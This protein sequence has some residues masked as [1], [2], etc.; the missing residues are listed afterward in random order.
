MS[1]TKLYT[2]I[3]FIALALLSLIAFQ[4]YWVKNTYQIKQEQFDKDAKRALLNT[5]E[6]S[7]KR[8]L[9]TADEFLFGSSSGSMPPKIEVKHLQ[10]SLMNSIH[11]Q[12]DGEDAIEKTTIDSFKITNIDVNNSWTTGSVF[13][14]KAI[15]LNTDTQIDSLYVE[16]I[17]TT[18]K[19]LFN[20]KP[21][22]PNYAFLD[23]VLATEFRLLGLGGTYQFGVLNSRKDSMLYASSYDI[24]IEF[25]K[26]NE[27]Y[28][29][30]LFSNQDSPYVLSVFFPNREQLILRRMLIVF[31][32]SIL[33]VLMIGGGFAYVLRVVMMQ[34]KLSEM[35]NDFINNMTH[36]LKTPIANIGLSLEALL[37][38]GFI[39]NKEKRS[40]Y[41]QIA[42]K[43]NKRLSGLVEQVLKAAAFEKGVADFKMEEQNLNELLQKAFESFKVQIDERDGLIELVTNATHALIQ[44]DKAH[45][46]GVI[47]NLLDNANKYSEGKPQIRIE[48]S[49]HPQGIQLVISDKG[50]GLSRSHQQ[51]I[52]DRFY[53]VNT[54]DLHNVKGYGLGLS[55]VMEV[56]R[57][58]NASIHVESQLGK[59]S[60]FIVL[61]PIQKDL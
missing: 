7:L 18:V 13:E 6:T 43:E 40:Q 11:I 12:V 37:T 1:K 39:E 44:G 25:L 31:I 17:H 15:T 56:L 10:D 28:H 30:V 60:R 45:L 8:Q 36:E 47:Y 29:S 35:K 48:T 23:S 26:G 46:N 55:Y 41:L 38:F 20:S 22:A 50:I 3:T 14:A 19:L 9:V 16:D 24:N 34:K 61:F 2:I 32:I 27:S 49:D 59:G 53:R 52:F 4:V 51:K 5:V 33:L 54:G 57:Y 21:Q 58:H 42:Q